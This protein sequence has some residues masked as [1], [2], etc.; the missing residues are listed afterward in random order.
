[1]SSDFPGFASYFRPKVALLARHRA[2]PVPQPRQKA[3]R[4]TSTA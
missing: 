1:M 4:G 3:G 2:T